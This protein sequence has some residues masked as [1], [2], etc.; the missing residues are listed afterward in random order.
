MMYATHDR[1]FHA[2]LDWEATMDHIC[3]LHGGTAVLPQRPYLIAFRGLS[4]MSRVVLVSV[5]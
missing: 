1:L 5:S 4:G 3:D 2:V